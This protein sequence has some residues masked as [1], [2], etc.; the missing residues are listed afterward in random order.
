M[1]FQRVDL[2]LILQPDCRILTHFSWPIG[3]VLPIDFYPC[4]HMQDWPSTECRQRAR[5]K[6]VHLP[7]TYQALSSAAYHV[8]I[9]SWDFSSNSPWD[10]MLTILFVSLAAY[11]R[12]NP[13]SWNFGFKRL[14]HQRGILSLAEEQGIFESMVFG[15]QVQNQSMNLWVMSNPSHTNIVL[16][17]FQTFLGKARDPAHWSCNGNPRGTGWQFPGR[18]VCMY[19]CTYIYIY[20][21]IYIY[22]SR[23]INIHIYIYTCIS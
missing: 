19:V 12:C 1:N 20:M 14:W 2:G 10:M 17:K 11:L 16:P 18:Y 5:K 15:A 7:D 6:W 23:N 4:L 3:E 13:K 9:L 8:R 21:Y 22:V